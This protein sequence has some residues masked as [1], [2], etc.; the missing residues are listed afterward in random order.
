LGIAYGD[1]DLLC[2][3]SKTGQGGCV[4]TDTENPMGRTITTNPSSVNN[5]SDVEC[6]DTAG[7]EFCAHAGLSTT[8]ALRVAS[9]VLN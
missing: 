3:Q 9:G 2:N 6:R 1:S 4:P 7:F 8:V 5:V